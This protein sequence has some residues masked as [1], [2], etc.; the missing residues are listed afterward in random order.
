MSLKKVNFAPAEY[1]TTMEYEYAGMINALSYLCHE[2]TAAKLEL[3]SLHLSIAIDEL[4]DHHL[5][6][7]HTG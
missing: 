2:A 6:K 1:V 4:K 3:V 7:V 5:P